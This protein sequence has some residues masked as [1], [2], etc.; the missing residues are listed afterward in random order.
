ELLAAFR[1]AHPQYRRIFAETLPPGILARQ[2]AG[3]AITIGN[4]RIS[5]QP[6]VYTAGKARIMQTPSWFSD[7]ATYASNKL[8]ILVQKGNPLHIRGLTDLGRNAVRVSMPNPA[9]EGIGRQ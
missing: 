5:L 7:T 8:A 4:L 9:W 6:D 1:K 2:I 3:G